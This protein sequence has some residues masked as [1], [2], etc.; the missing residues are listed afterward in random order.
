[1]VLLVVGLIVHAQQPEPKPIQRTG[2]QDP[3]LNEVAVALADLG[4][5][6]R[7]RS[8]GAQIGGVPIEG[9]IGL[10]GER[11]Q[12]F[13]T[14]LGTDPLA[15]QAEL[16]LRAKPEVRAAEA[17]GQ[18]AV[19]GHGRVLYTANGRGGALDEFA[20]TRWCGSSTSSACRRRSRADLQPWPHLLSSAGCKGC[21]AL[22]GLARRSRMRSSS[23][24]SW[25]SCAPRAC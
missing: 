24:G 12:V 19:K 17:N 4:L 10:D 14:L 22:R 8:T 13:V 23:F 25:A 7:T 5:T 11:L 21:R 6:E 16:A 3:W 20:S 15:R 1:M 2:P 9:D 18:S